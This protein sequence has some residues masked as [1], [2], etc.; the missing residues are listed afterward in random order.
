MYIPIPCATWVYTVVLWKR[1]YYG[2][3]VHPLVLPQFP[4]GLKPIWKSAR[5]AQALQTVISHCLARPFS[6]PPRMWWD[7]FTYTTRCLLHSCTMVYTSTKC[8]AHHVTY[9]LHSFE[10]LV[11]INIDSSN[12][13][14][15][16]VQAQGKVHH[17][18]APFCKTT[19]HTCT[20]IRI[21]KVPVV[22]IEYWCTEPRWQQWCG[23]VHVLYIQ[24]YFQHTPC[25]RHTY[26][27]WYIHT[28]VH[29]YRCK[30]RCEAGL[31]ASC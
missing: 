8:L 26:I 23:H 5:L 24:M 19:V 31:V 27:H 29:T 7:W 11:V 28:L 22:Q 2:L 6:P 10:C 12:V 21:I 18:W 1:A 16:P 15:P 4:T 13:S 14:P 3:S 9:Y 30:P 20:C 17:P 25:M